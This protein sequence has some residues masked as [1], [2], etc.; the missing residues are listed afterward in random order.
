MPTASKATQFN[1]STNGQYL[2]IRWY[3]AFERLS[4]SPGYNYYALNELSDD[5][6]LPWFAYREVCNFSDFDDIMRL[7][8]PKDFVTFHRIIAKLLTSIPRH[9]DI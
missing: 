2:F 9:I 7:I 4:S 6:R 3:F 1:S 8:S 5:L